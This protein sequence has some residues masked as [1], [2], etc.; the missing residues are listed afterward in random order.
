MFEIDKQ[1]AKKTTNFFTVPHFVG[2]QDFANFDAK[3]RNIWT[4][5]ELWRRTNFVVFFNLDRR[6]LR[7]SPDRA[8]ALLGT[9]REHGVEPDGAFLAVWPPR[10]SYRGLKNWLKMT[11]PIPGRR[12]EGSSQQLPSQPRP[13]PPLVQNYN[14]G[15]LCNYI[16]GPTGQLWK[17]PRAPSI[18]FHN[19]KSQCCV[20]V[21]VQSQTMCTRRDVTAIQA[22]GFE[23]KESHTAVLTRK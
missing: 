5:R 18:R 6:W 13:P 17:S 12:G 1:T 21:W 16:D 20:F 14:N 11:T 7:L 15:Q 9:M 4:A 19:H 22:G 8:T 3:S 2:L 23:A 10:A